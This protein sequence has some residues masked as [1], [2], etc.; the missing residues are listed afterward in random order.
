MPSCC[1][2]KD[3]ATALDALLLF[4]RSLTLILEL[5]PRGVPGKTRWRWTGIECWLI[6]AG[7]LRV[8]VLLDGS[9]LL[10]QSLYTTPQS[11]TALCR[12]RGGTNFSSTLLRLITQTDSWRGEQTSHEVIKPT[13]NYP[14]SRE[15]PCQDMICRDGL[16]TTKIPMRH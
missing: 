7:S 3:P 14:A 5:P 6:R 12:D 16:F 13:A 4:E 1:A 2:V 10:E 9:C 11:L 15:K 8:L